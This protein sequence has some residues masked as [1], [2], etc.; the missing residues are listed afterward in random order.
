MGFE[1]NP[2]DTCVANK[3]IDGKQCTIAWYV[4]NNKISHVDEQVVTGVIER[5]KE[6]F[7]KMAVT[8]G[9]ARLPGHG[10]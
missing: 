4:D 9:K 7:G 8:R 2:Y 5:I 10:H 6:R 3:T 1:L